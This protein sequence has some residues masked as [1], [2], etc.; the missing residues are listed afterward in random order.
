MIG[1]SLRIPGENASDADK[2]EFRQKLEKI[3]MVP[4]DKF[5]DFVR[6]EKAEQYAL[7]NPPKD[8]EKVITQT[9]IDQLK[10]WAHKTGLAPSQFEALVTTRIE[11][12]IESAKK[13]QE[14]FAGVDAVL[15]AKY[16]DA[17]VNAAKER[18]LA[19]A[20][21]FNK[22]LAD[23]LAQAPDADTLIALAEVGK[24]F[25][26]RGMGDLTPQPK[27]T[28]SPE[29]AEMKLSEIA[30]NKAHAFHN[31]STNRRAYEAAAAEV[32]RLRALALGQQPPQGDYMFEESA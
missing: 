4:K 32:M 7:T 2:T 6:P 28:E 18:A 31:R 22:P 8:A 24:M 3:G 17:G 29:E 15:K 5:T 21:K 30:N 12:R 14:Q 20:L 9:E 10:E 26:E 13:Q 11:E 23:K 16:G 1:N 19:A 25:Q 27:F